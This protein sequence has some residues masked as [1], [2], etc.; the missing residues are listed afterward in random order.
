DRQPHIRGCPLCSQTAWPTWQGVRARGHDDWRR[1]G[2]FAR[3]GFGGAGQ[4]TGRLR[5]QV[6]WSHASY[7]AVVS[8]DFDEGAFSRGDVPD[9]C[10]TAGRAAV[11]T[12]A[13][14]ESS[15]RAHRVFDGEA[16]KRG[17]PLPRHRRGGSFW[18][19]QEPPFP[20]LLDIFFGPN[21]HRWLPPLPP[22]R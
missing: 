4:T 20:G 3:D 16:I 8:F 7:A 17:K 22:V 6:S 15:A 5:A 19:T 13:N 2:P 10:S 18:L 1:F 9:H 14:V 21:V 12:I 11:C